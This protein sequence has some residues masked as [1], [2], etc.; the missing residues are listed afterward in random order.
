MIASMS[1]RRA[2]SSRNYSRRIRPPSPCPLDCR[3]R[4]HIVLE[5]RV[6]V[7]P[8]RDPGLARSAACFFSRA[9][10]TSRMVSGWASSIPGRSCRSPPFPCRRRQGLGPVAGPM[11]ATRARAVADSK[12]LNFIVNPF[13]RGLQADVVV[14]PSIKPELIGANGTGNALACLL[15]RVKVMPET[16]V[17]QK[18]KARHKPGLPVLTA[19]DQFLD[20]IKETPVFCHQPPF[21]GFQC[22]RLRRLPRPWR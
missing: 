13:E 8:D 10:C 16:P 17:A 14:V 18:K 21:L 7:F 9:C 11:T 2:C 19:A 6:M 1:L 12:V 20:D 22:D 4:G 5:D 3:Q 15:V